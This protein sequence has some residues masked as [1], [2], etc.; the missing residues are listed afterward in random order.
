MRL[1]RWLAHTYQTANTVRARKQAEIRALLLVQIHDVVRAFLYCSEVY[2]YWL[3]PKMT[4][5]RYKTRCKNYRKRQ[6]R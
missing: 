1:T 5:R 2:D 4:V 3:W 6:P